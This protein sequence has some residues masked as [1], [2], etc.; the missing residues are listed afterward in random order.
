MRLFVETVSLLLLTSL[1]T[2]AAVFAE[3]PAVLDPV[4]PVLRWRSPVIKISL[5]TS[6]TSQNPNIKNGTVVTDVVRRSLASWENISA[7]RFTESSSEKQSVSPAGG[8]GDGVSLITIAQTPENLAL[9]QGAAQTNSARTRVFYNRRGEITEADIV[10]NPLAQFSDDGTLGT[11]DLQSTLTHEIGHLLGLEHSFSFGSAMFENKGQNGLFGLQARS[12]RSLSPE[13]ISSLQRLYGA[14]P[15][16]EDCCGVI[17]GRIMLPVGKRLPPFQVWTEDADGRVAASTSTVRNGIFRL[18]GLQPGTYR[19]FAQ[20]DAKKRSGLVIEP[21]EV[22]VEKG[23]SSSI[24]LNTRRS[25]SAPEIAF[26]GL[27]GQLAQAATPVNAGRMYVLYLGGAGLD[28][29]KLEIG[30]TSRFLSFDRTTFRKYDFSDTVAALRIEVGIDADTPP[31]DY[32]IFVQDEAGN[33]RFVIGGVKVTA[34]VD[35]WDISSTF[36][37]R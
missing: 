21:S 8:T 29:S 22:T 16:D 24:E 17:S 27:N 7:I 18:E 10:L 4:P 6:I 12:G 32:S 37:A 30:S 35:P 31:G 33:R 23:R 15:G 11:F 28:P 9:F 26:V 1:V 5:S 13:D 14:V 19:V 34:F 3:Q 36:L 2:A 20:D 25:A